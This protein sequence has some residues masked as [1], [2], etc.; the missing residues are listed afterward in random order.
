MIIMMQTQ[1]QILTKF[2]STFAFTT[3]KFEETGVILRFIMDPMEENIFLEEH[4]KL[5]S[6]LWMISARGTN[7]VL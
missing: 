5:N 6:V 4:M 2:N 1:L 3:L 7:F